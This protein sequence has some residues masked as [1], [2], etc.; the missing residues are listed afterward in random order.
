MEEERTGATAETLLESLYARAGESEK[1]H[2]RIYD[3]KAIETV[4]K[5]RNDV[6]GAD[7]DAVMSDAV[8]ARTIVLDHMVLA[9]IRKHPDAVII[10]LACGMDTRFDRVDNGTI[11]W[12][13]VDLPVTMELR[14][15]YIHENQRVTNITASAMEEGW[16]EGISQMGKPVLV[17]MEGFSMYLQEKDVRQIL[18]VIDH[19]FSNVTVYMDLCNPLFR[20][21]NRFTYGAESGRELIHLC[22]SFHWIEDVSLMEGMK[23]TEPVYRLIEKIGFVRNL[24]GKIAVIQK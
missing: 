2:P 7:K 1:P 5:I 19:H 6:T 22:P 4:K 11:R 18:S 14:A 13:N 16:T 24:A 21:K 10:N 3:S 15:E 9:Y 20:K 8:I 23:D 17:I 12:Y